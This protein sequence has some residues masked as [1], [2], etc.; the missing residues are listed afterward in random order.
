MLVSLENMHV[1]M[2]PIP[3]PEQFLPRHMGFNFDCIIN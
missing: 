1:I 2:P 3:I